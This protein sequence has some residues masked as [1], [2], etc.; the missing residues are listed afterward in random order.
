MGVK[1]SRLGFGQVAIGS[2]KCYADYKYKAGGDPI[3]SYIH[4]KPDVPD[5]DELDI[6]LYDYNSGLSGTNGDF[7]GGY[8]Y[9]ETE[10]ERQI[11]LPPKISVI[12]IGPRTRVK[13]Y[14]SDNFTGKSA[15][16]ENNSYDDIHMADC[17][18]LKKV[19]LL[20][21]IN[22]MY[23]SLIGDIEKAK[24]GFTDTLN[25]CISIEKILLIIILIIIIY[26]I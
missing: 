8:V 16:I 17:N 21:N 5:T 23:V 18:D 15:V 13:L 11:Y 12:W 1:S 19:D 26:K 14:T 20:N 22:S 3:V 2:K 7:K 25:E 24:E 9:S 4:K 6:Y 10:E